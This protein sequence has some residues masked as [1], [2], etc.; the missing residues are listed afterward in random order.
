MADIAPD[1]RWRLEH[2]DDG[3]RAHQDQIV[4]AIVGQELAQDDKDQHADKRALERADAADH[5]HEDDHHRPVVDAES[6]FRRYAQ[7]LQKDQPADQTGAGRGHDIDDEFGAEGV[8]AEAG[9]RRLGSRGSPSAPGRAA[10]AATDRRRRTRSPRSRASSS[11]GSSR[12]RRDRARS[13]ARWPASATGRSRRPARRSGS[14][15]AQRLR[16][17]PMCRPR[18]KRRAAETPRSKPGSTAG[19]QTGRRCSSAT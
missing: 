5:H 17:P 16:R 4:G 9:R 14:P 10:S 8:D 19:P 18:N 11:K 2:D 7:L 15:T 13:A 1:S 3:N 6:G 12:A